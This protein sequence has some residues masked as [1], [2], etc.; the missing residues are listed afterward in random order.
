MKGTIIAINERRG[1]VG[2]QTEND[3]FS[4]FELLGGDSIEVGDEVSWKDDTSLGST[5]LT[6]ITDGSCFEVFFQNHWVPKNQLRQQL[7]ME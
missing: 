3:D 7:M 2:V 4:V 1:M 6:N 5:T